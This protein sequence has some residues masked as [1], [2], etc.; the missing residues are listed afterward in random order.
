M[1]PENVVFVAGRAVA[2]IDFDLIRPASRLLDVVNALVWWAP[3]ADPVDRYPEMVE[4]DPVARCR[5]FADAYGLEPAARSDLVEVAHSLAGRSLV[6]M[7]H[8]AVTLGGGWARMWNEGV[9]DTISRRRSW[10]AEEG[11]RITAALL[12]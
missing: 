8:R 11:P 2:L 6:L 3:L 5:V 1:T 4:L 7:R 12:G 10:L 9:G